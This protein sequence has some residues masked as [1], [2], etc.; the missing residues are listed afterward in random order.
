MKRFYSILLTGIC[1]MMLLGCFTSCKER[2]DPVKYSEQKAFPVTIENITLAAEP[3]SIVCLSPE[4][5][6]ALEEIDL[7]EKVIGIS[8]DTTQPEGKNLPQLG[9][10]QKPDT[11]Q[12]LS[13][14]PDLVITCYPFSAKEMEEL[15]NQSVQVL[16]L[17]VTEDS[18]VDT[19]SL[20]LLRG[21]PQ[22]ESQEENKKS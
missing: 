14:K 9:T 2:K 10:A 17:P 6:S 21:N 7:S 13:L 1:V 4:I 3:E 20:V 12:I 16:V 15:Q 11:T 19:S 18:T 22:E 5:Y 8:S